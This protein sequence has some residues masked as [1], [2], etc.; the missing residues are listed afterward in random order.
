MEE[1]LAMKCR[2]EE[3]A[4]TTRA[5]LRY[6]KAVLWVEAAQ[7]GGNTMTTWVVARRRSVCVYVCACPPVI[8]GDTVKHA[9]RH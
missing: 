9:L 5:S 1:A 3:E 8:G 2:Q 7:G 4:V 6:R